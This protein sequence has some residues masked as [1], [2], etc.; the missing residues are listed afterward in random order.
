MF[1]IKLSLLIIIPIIGAI[2]IFFARKNENQREAVSFIAAF[3]LFGIVLNLFNSS[4][5]NGEI[6]HLIQLFPS[7]HCFFLRPFKCFICIRSVF[8]MD[9]DN[10][11]LHRLYERSK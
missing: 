6:I 3:F 5:I 2:F 11:V 7:I 8:P 10:L 9:C 1:L 4:T